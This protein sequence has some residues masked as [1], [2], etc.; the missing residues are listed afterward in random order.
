MKKILVPLDG[1]ELADRILGHVA[2]VLGQEPAEVTLLHVSPP[3][4]PEAERSASERLRVAQ[5]PAAVRAHLEEVKRQLESTGVTVAI[6]ERTGEPAAVILQTITESR[7][8]LVAMSSHARG[9]F[10]RWL[11]GSVA[12]D[13]VIGARAPVLLV[14]PRTSKEG[15][16][17]RLRR[18]LVPLDGT[19]ETA[20]VLPLVEDL[21]RKHEAEVILARVAWEGLSR[22]LL[23]ATLSTDKLLESLLPWEEQLS[24]RGLRVRRVAEH[25]DVASTIVE[26]AEREDVDL[27]AMT[28][29]VHGE[30]LKLLE[31]SMTTRVLTRAER[32]LLVL[33]V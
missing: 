20:K 15:A 1:S 30:F 28:T 26:L 24:Q 13:V 7:P 18:I 8:D 33:H 2:N 14:T 19:E 22:P 9:A 10:M 5:D 32:P 23:A 17:Q 31:T 4:R 12:A 27:I 16:T 25:G 29:H 6:L 3:P 21:A 11:R